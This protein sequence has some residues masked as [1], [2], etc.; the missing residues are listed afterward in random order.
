MKKSFVKSGKEFISFHLA[1]KLV[2]DI[3]CKKI[4]SYDIDNFL[5]TSTSEVYGS[6]VMRL[7]DKY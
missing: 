4:I 7:A 3:L 5:N 6:V 2:K 1:E